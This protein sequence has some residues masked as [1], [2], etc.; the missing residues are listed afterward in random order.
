[1]ECRNADPPCYDRAYAVYR[2]GGTGAKVL[3]AFKFGAHRNLGALFTRQLLETASHLR[4]DLGAIDAWVP[5]PPRPGKIRKTGWDQVEALARN[6]ERSRPRRKTEAGTM[7]VVRCLER[8][9]SRSQ[10]ELNRTERA[11]NL[12]GKIRCLGPVPETALLFD[13]VLTTGATM[14]ACAAAL[15]KAGTARVYAL[16]LFYD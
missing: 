9:P 12:I 1:M 6:L 2:Y 7:P 10:K 3:Q 15:K 11:A 4:A 16:A 14:N 5:V 13:D 8:L